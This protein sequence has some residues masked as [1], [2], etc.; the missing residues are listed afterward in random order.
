MPVEKEIERLKNSC[1]SRLLVS[2]HSA[3]AF[4]EL[5]MSRT[6]FLARAIF[7]PALP[8]AESSAGTVS[9]SSLQGRKRGAP[10]FPA[11]CKRQGLSAMD[12]VG[13]KRG[14]SKHA[15]SS[16]AEAL[17]SSVSLIVGGVS[18][19]LISLKAACEFA[20]DDSHFA[21]QASEPVL[22]VPGILEVLEKAAFCE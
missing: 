15:L 10:G 2:N 22:V 7:R 8:S 17:E 11:T 4:E 21:S 12:R 1:G 6:S 19:S 3:H 18:D 16:G 20:E 5:S 13:P 14:A 9:S